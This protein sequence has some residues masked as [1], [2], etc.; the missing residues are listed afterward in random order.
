M[1]IH[2]AAGGGRRWSVQRQG[3][4]KVD[5]SAAYFARYVAKNV[6]ASGLAP[7]VRIQVAYAIG[8]ADPVGVLVDTME[9]AVFRMR[10]SQR[11]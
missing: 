3:P 2:T 4:F 10:P 5:R 1:W 8:V 6:V 9:P 7:P 11:R